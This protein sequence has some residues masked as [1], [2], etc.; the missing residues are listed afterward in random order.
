MRTKILFIALVFL[1]VSC[2][3]QQNKPE[4]GLK[5]NPERPG[6]TSVS[7]K[8]RSLDEVWEA[9]KRTVQESYYRSIALDEEQKSIKFATRTASD[10]VGLGNDNRPPDPHGAFNLAIAL[11]E[12]DGVVILECYISGEG[13]QE[14]GKARESSKRIAIWQKN[15]IDRFRSALE[16]E[17]K[18]KSSK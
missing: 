11:A 1:M 18:K 6:K 7:F 3:V 16:K 10:L 17:L 13:K 4:A 2:A 9:C 14:E 8:D 15:E 5:A 12:K